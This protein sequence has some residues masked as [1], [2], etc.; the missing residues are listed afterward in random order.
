MNNLYWEVEKKKSDN[1]SSWQRSGKSSLC[2]ELKVIMQ[3]T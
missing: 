1:V 2:N 3:L